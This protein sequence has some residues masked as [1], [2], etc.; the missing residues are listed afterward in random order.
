MSCSVVLKTDKDQCSTNADCDAR[1]GDLVGMVCQS[2]VCVPPPDT[3]WS[4]VGKVPPPSSD[5]T[6]NAS[7]RVIDLIAGKPPADGTV[8]LCNKFDPPC[9]G[10]ISQVA[11]PAD[12]LVSNV[13]PATF[14]GFYYITTSTDRPTLF[15]VDTAAPPGP[16]TVA[17]LT[18]AASDALN[19]AFKTTPRPNSGSVS[20]TMSDCNGKKAAGIHFDID[21]QEGAIPYYVNGSAVSATA[22]AT[23]AGGSGGFA[24]LNEGTLTIRATVAKTGQLVAT[25]TS[26]IR[27]AT[28]T[29]QR[30]SP[31]AG[32]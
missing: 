31:R 32:Q 6:F 9:N 5:Q 1:G 2:Q 3:S 24:N 15:F 14:T 11:M 13:V 23:D 27:P 28:I 22:T 17:L 19:V 4:C 8:R 12:G 29:Y 26:L 10:P 25:A 16:V 30:I 7:I 20:I 18:Q 21:A